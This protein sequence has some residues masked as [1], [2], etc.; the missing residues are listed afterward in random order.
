MTLT[1]AA[2]IILGMFIVTFGIRFCLYARA[3]KVLLPQWLDKALMFVPVSV[4]AAIIMPM[5][6]IRDEQ[7][8]ITWDNPW[9]IGAVTA[10]TIGLWRQNQLLT[11]ATGVASFY[12][13]RLIT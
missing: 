7:L 9:L 6:L 4:L 2:L 1:T 11:I 8:T 5:I 3:H 10:F 12:I 13:V